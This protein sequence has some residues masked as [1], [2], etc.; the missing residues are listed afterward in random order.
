MV[1][2]Q[3]DE[4]SER[5]L[6]L[7]KNKV[8]IIMLCGGLGSGKSTISLEIAK[9]LNIK[10]IVDTDVIRETLRGEYTQKERP[11]LYKSSYNS[12][13]LLGEKNDINIIK[14][15][16][17]YS[18]ELEHSIKR[19]LDRAEVLG[20]DMII[21]GIHLIPSNFRIYLNKK[22]V[23]Y[24]FLYSNETQQLLN[25][26]SRKKEFHKKSIDRFLNNYYQIRK[27]T[28]YLK[29]DAEKN[30]CTIIFNKNIISTIKKIMGEQK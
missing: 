29:K 26:K 13:E 28:E 5:C 21:E 6:I 2:H 12:W 22:N 15:F 19:I 18:K 11:F 14:G 24:F 8:K 17:K 16:L 4:K 20:K 30:N 23:G 7:K 25:I 1:T 9:R 10:Q 3:V 27:I